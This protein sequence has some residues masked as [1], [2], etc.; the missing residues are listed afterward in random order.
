MIMFYNYI[1][2]LRKMILLIVKCSITPKEK[3]DI[4]N[5]NCLLK[6]VKFLDNPN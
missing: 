3:E 1:L 6:Y 5:P 2:T 4:N